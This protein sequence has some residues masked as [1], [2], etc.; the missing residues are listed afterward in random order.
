MDEGGAYSSEGILGEMQ[1]CI[2]Y[3]TSK[4]KGTR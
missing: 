3:C 2:L 1:D 4:L